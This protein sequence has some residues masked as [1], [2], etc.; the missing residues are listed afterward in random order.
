MYPIVQLIAR[1]EQVSAAGARVRLLSI[2]TTLVTLKSH[3]P[4]RRAP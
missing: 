4:K 3:C 1:T 2:L